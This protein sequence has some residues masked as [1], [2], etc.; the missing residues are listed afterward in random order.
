LHFRRF[1][2][3]AMID[4]PAE[5][6]S[7]KRKKKSRKKKRKP[8]IRWKTLLINKIFDLTIVIVGVTIA[9]QLNSWK[10]NSDQQSLARFYQEQLQADVAKDI[11]QCSQ[12]LVSLKRDHQ[13]VSQ[14]LQ[15]K[16]PGVDS[17]GKVIFNVLSLETF[18]EN[19]N[20][21]QTLVQ[22]NA[23]STLGDRML[24]GQLTEYY[25]TYT[26]IQRFE[27]V[28]TAALFKLHDFV[29]PYIDYQTQQVTNPALMDKAETRNFL[30]IAQA[31][32]NDGMEAHQAALD[33]AKALQARLP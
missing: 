3:S 24:V 17:L 25:A 11:E 1:N 16:N 21:Y 8:G 13:Y 10:V 2:L 22:G 6:H 26:S 4:E 19:S 20:T 30:M 28:Y 9:F 5:F 32:L 18:T 31:Q 14:Y 12:I 33:K 7:A 29:S 15:S 27:E 23:M